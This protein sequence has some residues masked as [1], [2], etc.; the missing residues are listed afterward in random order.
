MHVHVAILQRLLETSFEIESLNKNV[1]S[2]NKTVN[3]TI[4]KPE[5]IMC[6]VLPII[7]LSRISHDFYL[8]DN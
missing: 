8:I 1:A 6:L 4:I 2:P 3:Y 7:T 5:R